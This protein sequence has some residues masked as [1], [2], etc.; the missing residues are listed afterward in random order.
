MKA[1]ITGASGFVGSYLIDKLLQKGYEVVGLSRSQPE[2]KD[3]N[4]ISCDINDPAKVNKILK[5]AKPDEIYHLA[6]SAFI[7]DTYKDPL[8]AY[9]TI[10][11]GTLTLY[12]A[13]RQLELG[14]KILYVGSAEVYGDGRGK[15]FNEE[16]LLQPANPYAG[17][18]ACADLISEQYA[19][20]YQMNIIRARP[21]NHT[22]PKQSADF[23]CSSFAKQIA[24]MEGHG[25]NVIRVGNIHVKRDFLDVRDVVNAYFELLQ[26][27][28]NS[29]AYNVS[30]NKA[31]SISELLSW[32]FSFSNIEDPII[33]MDT[34]KIR[35][36][37]AA[38][39]LGNNSKLLQ[40]ITWNQEY[41]LKDTMREMLEYWREFS[42]QE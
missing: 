34:N 19:I 29:E 33:E 15:P 23:V 10:V 24:E 11:N 17:A 20:N 27:G 5:S 37:D 12:E 41:Q 25:R 18:K 42:G 7:P 6:G 4:F 35:D 8:G 16:D 13:I 14:S 31:V 40:D 26:Q 3:V 32:L 39:R 22:G 2:N 21:F 30:A 38:I 1:L 36:N 9:H 28:K